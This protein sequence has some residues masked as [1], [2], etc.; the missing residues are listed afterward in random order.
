MAKN[1]ISRIILAWSAVAAWA[2]LIF[3]LSATPGLGTGL[4]IWD[5]ILRKTAHMFEFG[6]LT[7]LVWRALQLH[8]L[9]HPLALALGMAAA[10]VYAMTDEYHQSFVEGRVG[11]IYDIGFDLAGIVIAAGL[12]LIYHNRPRY[13][14]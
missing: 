13:R 1:R 7:F 14:D 6:F 4:G 12:I 3:L 8:G 5:Y 2:A 11:S 9:R 10:L